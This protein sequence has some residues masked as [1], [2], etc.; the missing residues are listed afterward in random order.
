[1]LEVTLPLFVERIWIQMSY[2]ARTVGSRNTVLSHIEF[3]I[4]DAL[5]AMVHIKQSTTI[6]LY[7]VVRITLKNN[8]LRLE[9]KQGEPYL[10][11]FKCMNCRGDYQADSNLCLF[12]KH[13]F[14]REWHSKKYQELHDSRRQLICSTVSSVQV[15]LWKKSKSFCKMFERTIWLLIPS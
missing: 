14:H 13:W 7:S 8:P 2:S 15:W 10:H 4:L 12:W 5:N 9:T 11:T 1:M 3:K 6:I